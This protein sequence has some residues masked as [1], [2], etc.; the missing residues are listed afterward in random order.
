MDLVGE[1]MLAFREELLKSEPV[2]SL[3][4]L[5]KQITPPED[6]HR[7]TNQTTMMILFQMKVMSYMMGM[8]R[9]WKKKV[10]KFWKR[11]L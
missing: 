8:G 11:I 1:K 6:V 4:N 3:K 5:K 2:S 7:S 9:T 10:M